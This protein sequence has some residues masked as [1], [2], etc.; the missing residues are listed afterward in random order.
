MV[1][2]WRCRILP[3]AF[4]PRSFKS[5]YLEFLWR[6]PWTCQPGDQHLFWQVG[7][8]HQQ[9]RRTQPSQAGSFLILPQRATGAPGRLAFMKSLLFVPTFNANRTGAIR[10]ERCSACPFCLRLAWVLTGGKTLKASHMKANRRQSSKSSSPS[11]TGSR[12][13][14]AAF[15]L[16]IRLQPDDVHFA[17][18]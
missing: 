15:I 16:S 14:Q 5:S 6:T 11:S 8:G 3:R 9:E 7:W 18:P 2:K 12:W 1:P 13:S 4:F 10:S 17:L